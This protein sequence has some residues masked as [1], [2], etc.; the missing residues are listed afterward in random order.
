MSAR[1][2]KLLSGSAQY[3]ESSDAEVVNGGE[4]NIRVQDEE[5]ENYLMDIL[6]ELRKMN[7]YLSEMVGIEVYE[8]DI[9][10]E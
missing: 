6:W 9:E 1:S 4:T 10:R 5:A 3:I 7:T 2:R 8:E